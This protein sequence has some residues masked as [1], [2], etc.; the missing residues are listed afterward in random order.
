MSTGD[1]REAGTDPGVRE[2]PVEPQ[3]P[4][5]APV[6]RAAP[7]RPPAGL[8]LA[9]VVVLALVAGLAVL[10]TRGGGADGRPAPVADAGTAARDKAV[11]TILD[12][13]AAAVLDRDEKAWLADVDPRA[14]DFRR[15]QQV[16]FANLAQVRFASWDYELIGR[17]YDRPDLA[18]TYDVP[19][20]LPAMLVHYA[21]QGYDLGPVARPQVLTFVQ[22]GT[23][24]YVASDSDADSDLPETG[25][26]DPWDRRAMVARKGHHV[27]VLADAEDK[28]R[29]GALV[30]VSDAAVSAVA[31]MWPDGWRRKVVVVAVRDQQLIETYFRTELQTSDEVA[32][33]AVPAFDTVPGWTPRDETSY[34][35]T[36]DAATRSRVILNPRYFQP[37]NADNAVLLIH[38]V[39][40]VAT[41]ART[42]PGAPTWLV[43]G[44]ADYTAYRTLRPFSVTLPG[45][46]RKEVEAGSVDLPT[47][48]FYQHDVPAHYLAGFLACAFVSDRYGEGTLRRYYRSL[49]ATPR[50][51]QTT[52]RTQSVTKK[53]LGLST[54]ALQREVAAYGAG[55]AP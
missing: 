7:R 36:D 45:S 30:R 8:V 44:I 21:I 5:A 55:V 11:R 46:L 47:Y 1:H 52:A 13:R 26:A 4:D 43:E 16:V 27:L 37:G 32:A 22:R 23:R 28:G 34:D 10:L 12:R 38:E 53:V 2:A 33:I 20:H 50:E 41:Q 40:H 25:H 49:A 3:Q 29:L 54:V 39:T 48:D 42:L 15:A 9:A 31:R 51:I 6:H 24:W 35:A 18:D 17:D 14:A 19:Y